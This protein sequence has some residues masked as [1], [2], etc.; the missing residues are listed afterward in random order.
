MPCVPM[1]VSRSSRASGEWASCGIRSIHLVVGEMALF[2]SGIDEFRD[3]VK[4]QAESISAL[5][6]MEMRLCVEQQLI[7]FAL[8]RLK[9]QGKPQQISR[10]LPW[11]FK[12]QRAKVI[13]CCSTQ[14]L[15]SIHD[16]DEMDSAWLFTTSRNSSMPERKR[17]I[18][19]TTR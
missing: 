16:S 18:S 3:V 2:L 6:C 14:S 15:I 17:A 4:S 5:S 12:R 11:F 19:P 9:N 1:M 13:S 7:T 8:C 10:G